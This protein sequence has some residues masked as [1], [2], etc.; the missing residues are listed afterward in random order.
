MG[1]GREPGNW[2]QS[3]PTR[4]VGAESRGGLLSVREFGLLSLGE[5]GQVTRLPGRQ[6]ATCAP[7]TG[8]SH[9]G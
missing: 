2:E 9:P 5:G 7:V 8:T 6:D 4:P 3:P 1:L